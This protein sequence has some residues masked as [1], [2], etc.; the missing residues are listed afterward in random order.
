MVG[1]CAHLTYLLPLSSIESTTTDKTL[2]FIKLFFN[3]YNYIFQLFV[4]LI[5]LKIAISYLKKSYI[6]YRA[7]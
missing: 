3:I 4:I 6:K 5:V 2:S 7:F 1:K